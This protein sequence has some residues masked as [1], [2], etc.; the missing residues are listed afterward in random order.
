MA[1]NNLVDIFS[2]DAFSVQN[3]STAITNIPNQYGRVNELGV[4]NDEGIDTTAVIIEFDN[5]VLSLIPQSP[6]GTA[7]PKSKNGK[8]TAKSFLT[9]RLALDDVILPSDIQNKR[10]FGSNQLDTVSN[11][12]AK[13][14]ATLSRK[15]DITN[16]YLKCGALHG[17]VKDAD[18][19]ELLNL[20]DE[21]EIEEKAVGF[22]LASDSATLIGKVRDVTGHIEDNLMGDTMKHVHALCSPGWF[23][24]FITHKAVREAYQFYMA[25]Q[26]TAM[27]QGN[28]PSA[29]PLRDD[30]SKGFVWQGVFWE[31]YRGKAPV[32]GSDGEATVRDFIEADTVRFFP[33]GT[34]ET[35]FSY[36]A[37]ADWMETVNFIGQPKYAKVVPDLGG[38]HVEV[39]SQSCPLPLCT[40]PGV[41]VK[42]TKSA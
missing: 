23:A 2:A 25:M 38:R 19:S 33:A 10:A 37:P 14:L 31:E 18:G 11:E 41:L 27:A 36:N 3:L 7:A 4:F 8:R 26:A 12:V 40:R 32:I 34:S 1:R 16:E 21:F 9:P 15:H 13:K 35:F 28:G 22:N 39:L 42:G 24:D 20:Y 17:V 30:V 5:Q 6:R 29:N